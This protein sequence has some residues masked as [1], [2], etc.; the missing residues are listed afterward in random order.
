LALGASKI[1]KNVPIVLCEVVV[2]R[3]EMTAWKEGTN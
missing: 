2:I 3:D 1:V